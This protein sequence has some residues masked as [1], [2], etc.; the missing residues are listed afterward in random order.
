MDEIT[1]LRDVDDN[2]R[3]YLEKKKSWDN[4]LPELRALKDALRELDGFHLT[5]RSSRAAK[6]RAIR[7]C[8]H[9]FKQPGCK[10]CWG[11]PPPA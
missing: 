1:L 10:G 3:R 4:R 7:D 2:V 9:V 5:R 11:I 6:A 8:Q